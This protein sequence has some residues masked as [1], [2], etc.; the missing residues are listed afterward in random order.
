MNLQSILIE[1]GI[2]FREV[3]SHEHAR[4]GWLQVDCPFCSKGS[5]HF[6]LGI[7]TTHWY[8]NCW[9]CGPHKLQETLSLLTGGTFHE[10]RE[11]V[12]SFEKGSRV[13]SQGVL[14]EVGVQIPS[15]LQPL[16]EPHRRYLEGR[17][18][19]PDLITRLWGIKGFVLHHKYSWR[20]WIPV[21]RDGQVVTWTARAIGGDG[22]RYL[23]PPKGEGMPTSKVLY[24][25]D[26]AR[27]S[28][29]V[30]EGP[31]DVWRLGPGAVATMG[32]GY[33]HHHV[34]MISKY[35]VRG[36]CFDRELAA[37][38][39]AK[40][41]VQSLT[42]LPGE[43]YLIQLES[44]T[45]LGDADQGEIDEIRGKFLPEFSVESV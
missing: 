24:G 23:H 11:W 44:G 12:N 5:E 35:P 33:S 26:Y 30:C 38:T 36:I 42:P 6:R 41:L 37:Q 7:N 1:R 18:F 31:T 2:P 29:V 39:R 32:L 9:T 16:R 14:Q 28:I 4:L 27:D 20:I 25:E 10:V 15:G 17:G 21:S 34:E 22:P 8:A 3:G 13:D 19:D 43:T 45:D 40:S